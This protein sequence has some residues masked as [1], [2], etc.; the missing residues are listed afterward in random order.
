MLVELGYYNFHV[1]CMGCLCEDEGNQAH[2]LVVNSSNQ[3]VEYVISFSRETKSELNISRLRLVIAYK[4]KDQ[5]V[6]QH[7]I[8]SNLTSQVCV[9]FELL[10]FPLKFD[11]SSSPFKCLLGVNLV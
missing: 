11:K 6:N 3:V 10:N 5:V 7:T 2:N 8:S 9:P 1:T 4:N